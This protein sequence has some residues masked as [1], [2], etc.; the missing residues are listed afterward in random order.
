MPKQA[1][2]RSCWPM[3]CRPATPRI[4]P[5]QHEVHARARRRPARAPPA[6]AAASRSAVPARRKRLRQAAADNALDHLVVAQCIGR[7]G[8]YVLAVAQDGQ[9]VAELAHLAH[10]MRDEH[11]GH[12]LAL[13]TLDDA[14]QPV[15]VAPGQR[16][17]GL[18]QQQMRG[19]RHSARAI[20]TFWRCASSSAPASA[21]R[22]T[23]NARPRR[24]ASTRS[25][26]R[27]DHAQRSLRRMGQQHVV[28]HAQVRHQRHFLERGLDAQ[29]VRAASAARRA[30]VH[31]QP[32]RAGLDQPD[33]NLT[34][35][36]LPAPFSPSSACAEPGGMSRHVVHRHR[37]AIGL[38]QALRAHRR[39]LRGAT[40]RA[41]SRHAI[42]MPRIQLRRSAGM[43]L[44]GKR[45]ALR[46]VHSFSG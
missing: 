16:G 37:G 46:G 43:P 39:R 22:S 6:P 41:T 34:M 21:R 40:V 8:G 31:P 5:P 30:A 33:S 7:T 32:S 29:R 17:R 25:A 45:A 12:A 35:V 3:P 26:A 15:H 27:G 42:G 2:N 24:C 1:L 10:A 44:E 4:S 36:D 13:E 18:V 11:H 14:A 28:Q 23:S 38:A 19:W 20:S 9:A